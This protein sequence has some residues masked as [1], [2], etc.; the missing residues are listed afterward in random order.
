VLELWVINKLDS[1][2]HD[3]VGG[4]HAQGRIP[5]GRKDLRIMWKP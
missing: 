2:T 5:Y 3:P 4:K 1:G